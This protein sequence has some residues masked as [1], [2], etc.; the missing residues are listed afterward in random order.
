MI[1]Q[2]GACHFQSFISTSKQESAIKALQ[3]VEKAL[4]ESLGL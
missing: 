1:S 3:T 4:D 2:I